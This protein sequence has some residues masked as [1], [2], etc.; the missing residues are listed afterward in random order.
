MYIFHRDI[1]S[2]KWLWCGCW[3]DANIWP[4]A[5]DAEEIFWHI[6]IFQTFPVQGI[7][8]CDRALT[9]LLP[10]KTKTTPHIFQE[11]TY[12]PS[13]RS[14]LCA[15]GIQICLPPSFGF[16]QCGLNC[17]GLILNLCLL[18]SSVA[19]LFLFLSNATCCESRI[20]TLTLHCLTWCR[21]V[22]ATACRWCGFVSCDVM[23][24]SSSCLLPI[25]VAMTRW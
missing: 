5:R 16:V 3:L 4:A 9:R 24:I 6:I 22:V 14:D 13:H 19:H 18:E 7:E 10:T 12:L 25:S 2:L 17:T 21:C 1:W 23:R 20:T 15:C 11:T 8:A